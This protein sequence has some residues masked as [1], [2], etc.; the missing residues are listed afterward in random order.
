MKIVKI[1]VVLVVLLVLL[2][3]G[4]LAFAVYSIDSLAKH[5][6]EKGATYALDVP[7]SLSSADVGILS[8]TFSMSG[9]TVSNPEGFDTPHFLRLGDGG[10][11]VSL[12]TLREDTVELPSL[13]LTDI[14]VHLQRSGGKSN[15]KVILENLKRLESGDGGGAKEPD[16][17]AKKFVIREVRVENIAAHVALLPIGGDATRVDVTVPE[18]VLTDVGEGGVPMSQLVNVLTQAILESIVKVGGGVIPADMLNDLQ[19][20]LAQLDSLKDVGLSVLDDG[21]KVIDSFGESVD[22]FKKGAEDAA[23]SIEDAA[24]GVQDLFGG[25]KKDDD[26]K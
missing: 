22:D 11:S 6:I 16:P 15:Y 5:G 1:L 25:K 26:E 23:K 19:G 12:G 17:N 7:T 24:K 4:A 21:G 13:T 10:V 14:D 9:L 18:I 2:V 20:Q 8:G 3:G